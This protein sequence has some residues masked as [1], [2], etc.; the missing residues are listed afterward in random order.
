[1]TKDRKLA[2]RIEAILKKKKFPFPYINNFKEWGHGD[3][4]YEIDEANSWI[5][6]ISDSVYKMREDGSELTKIAA[7]NCRMINADKD[8][9][10]SF[11][12]RE[13]EYSE[14]DEEHL[15]YNRYCI[16]VLCTI[17]PDGNIFEGEPTKSSLGTSD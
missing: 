1:M 9:S 11:T 4:I 13:E 15:E 14:L 16:D 10:V 7:G 2:E 6:F 12:K 3:I 8:G 17:T 5:F